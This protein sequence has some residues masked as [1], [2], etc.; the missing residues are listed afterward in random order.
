VGHGSALRWDL[1]ARSPLAGPADR[2]RANCACATSHLFGLVQSLVELGTERWTDRSW[3]PAMSLTGP[4]HVFAGLHEDAA[5]DFLKAFFTTRPRYLHYGSP[6]F[7]PATTVA[8]TQISAIAFP[9]IPGGIQWA[10][11]FQIPV[12]D[13]FPDSSGGMPAQLALDKNM[14]SINTKVRLRLGCSKGVGVAGERHFPLEPLKTSLVVWA[15]GEPS[16]VTSGPGV[17]SV[18]L[19]LDQVEIVDIT[20]DSLE[21]LLE[22]LVRMLLQS[23]LNRARMPLKLI[24]AG[25]FQLVLT[26]GPEISD[27]QVKIWGD[28]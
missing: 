7:V 12:L 15:V 2:R 8:E 19:E 22:C 18:G 13:F 25:A 14:F 9:G 3:V 26:N 23:A 6:F 5:N 4:D 20:P 1:A 16:V 24:S 17:G 11:D 10:V 27:D 28:I 21:E